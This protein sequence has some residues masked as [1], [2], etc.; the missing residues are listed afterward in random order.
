[1][2]NQNSSNNSYLSKASLIQAVTTPLGF[3]ALAVLVTEAI[4]GIVAASSEGMQRTYIILGM[5]G[6]LILLIVIVAALAVRYPTALFLTDSS[7]QPA[8]TTNP[9]IE[10][11]NSDTFGPVFDQFLAKADAVVMVGTGLSLLHADPRRKNLLQRIKEGCQVEIYAANPFSPHVEVRL[12]EEETA[13][14]RPLIALAGLKKWLKD[15]L[16]EKEKLGSRSTFSL[17][18]FPYYPTYAFFIFTK[19]TKKD[20]FFYPYGYTQLGTLSPVLSYTNENPA[21]QAMTRFLESQYKRVQQA[22]ADAKLIF[23]VLDKNRARPEQLV[24]FA[25]YIIPSPD[26]S[27]YHFGSEVLGYDVHKKSVQRTKWVNAVGAAADFGFHLTIADAL[28]CATE[29][30]IN[31]ISEEVQFLAQGFRP[32]K[33]TLSL[34]KDFPNNKGIAL[35]CNDQ[36]GSLEALHHEMVARVYRMAVASNYSLKLAQADRDNDQERADLM[37]KRYFAPYILQRF[38]PHFSLLSNVPAEKK[39]Q[40]FAE[41]K[42]LYEKRVESPVIEIRS[43]AIMQRPDPAGRWQILNEYELKG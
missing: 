8:V 22:S 3:F 36:T 25:V 16:D 9:I 19:G 4:L 21:D 1:M 38:K 31:L 34:E 30:D 39:D 37:I 14:P 5:I 10:Y 24:A 42:E 27:L 7:K 28:Y 11:S 12:I 40:I 43:I 41:I 23:D 15:L 13:S 18:L 2:T 32:F 20:Y 26:S 29:Q 33:L 6:T 35:V 17:K